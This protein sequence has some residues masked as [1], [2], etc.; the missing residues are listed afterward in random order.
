VVINKG[1]IIAHGAPGEIKAQTAGKRIRCSTRTDLDE[2][3]QIPGVVSATLDKNI[4]EIRAIEAENVRELLSR[5]RAL[6]GLEVTSAGLEDAFLALTREN[7][8]MPLS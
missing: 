8:R 7:N 1:A 5:D 6:S 2:A 3:R 4:L